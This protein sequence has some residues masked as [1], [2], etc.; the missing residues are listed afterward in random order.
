MKIDKTNLIEFLQKRLLNDLPANKSHEK[1]FPIKDGSPFRQSIPESTAKKS[2]VLLL[3]HTIKE[4]DS[5][6]ILFTL[7]SNKLKKHSNQI[8]FP[9]G[10]LDKNESTQ[11]AA[12]RETWEEVG[13]NPNKID[14][15]GELTEIFVPP[16]NSIIT[17]FIGFS[18]SEFELEINPS[19]VSEA[20][21]TDLNEI[22][23]PD[24]KKTK[25]IDFKGIGTADVPFY[26]VH[27]TVPLWGAT[28]IILSE[29][30]DIASE[31]K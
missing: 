25:K 4:T 12:L 16:S 31:F 15:I 26:D 2:A 8:S 13:I 11:D 10:R 30:I 9:G 17:P 7:R 19:E 14:I 22:L 1:M 29:F 18:N 5:L 28:A 24:I 3:L 21:F 6:S 23:N 20:F 27:P